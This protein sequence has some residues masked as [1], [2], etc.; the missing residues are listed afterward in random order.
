MPEAKHTA[1]ITYYALDLEKRELERTLAEMSI[2]EVGADLQGKV[3][4][5][6]MWG[7]YDGGLKFIDEG[8]LRGRDVI[9]TSHLKFN[10]LRD[11]SPSSRGSGSSPTVSSTSDA[12]SEAITPSSTPDSGQTPLHILFLGSSLGNFPRGADAQFLRNLP[13]RPGSGDTLLL[14]LDH[15]N[16]ATEIE[17]AYNDSKGITKKFIMNGSYTRVSRSSRSYEPSFR[18][19]SS[20]HSFG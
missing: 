14:G 20:G 2:S 17:A 10:D 5:K 19:Q 1:P 7:T 9:S 18:P 12:D 16:D 3:S 6:G 4:T 11:F 8:G 13:L 15:D